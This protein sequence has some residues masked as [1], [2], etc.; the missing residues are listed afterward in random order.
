MVD[1]RSLHSQADRDRVADYFSN[2]LMNLLEPAGRCW[3]LFTPWHLDDMNARLKRNELYAL[4]RRA[5]GASLE[6]VWQG[7]W[8]TPLL[9]RRKEEIGS[10]S[11]ARGYHLQPVS[12][13]ETPI[14]PA[15]VRYL[16]G[17][18]R[19]RGSHPRGRSGRLG[20]C[21]R[22]PQR[23]GG[24]GEDQSRSEPRNPRP[25]LHRPPRPGP[26]TRRAHRRVRSAI[27]P[28]G[29]PLRVERGLSG[30]EGPVRDANAFRPQAQERD[31]IRPQGRPR[32]RLQRRGRERRVPASGRRTRNRTPR[33]ANSTRR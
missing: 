12:E 18:G 19:V 32:G 2:N 28:L 1:V 17:R 25:R 9:A 7:A 29:D 6:P 10:A 4:L 16:D 13:E 5:I 23:A 24:A 26:R 21:P 33:S 3:V 15:W 30:L 27:Q 14:R 31:A 11:F 22:R 8:P 20:R